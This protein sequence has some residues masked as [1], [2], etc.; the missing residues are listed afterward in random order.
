MKQPQL[1]IDINI[2]EYGKSNI[3]LKDISFRIENNGI[4]GVFGKNGQGKSTFLK[5][6]AGLKTYKGEINF[7]HKKLEPHQ[8][9]YIGTEPNVYE[10]LTAREFY[11]FYE[12]V[13]G[14]KIINQDHK[15]FDIDENTILK[16]MSTGNLKKAYINAILQFSDYDI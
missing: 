13:S 1:N 2:V 9:A 5:T 11:K 7:N 10:Y 8:I 14:R 4:Y 16:S 3:I 12:K 15:I 6:I